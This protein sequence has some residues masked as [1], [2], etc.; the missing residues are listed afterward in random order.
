MAAGNAREEAM[1]QGLCELI[2]RDAWTLA[3]I[4]AHLLPW[5]RH[6]VADPQTLAAAQDDHQFFA[7]VDLE[8][9]PAIPPFER[10]GLHPILHDITS[11]I[12]IPTVFAAVADEAIP[13]FPMVH[14]GLGSHPDARVAAG[15]ALIE[16]AQSRCVDIQGV[17]EDLEPMD[18]PPSP[19]NL[20]TRRLRS[21]NRRQWQLGQSKIRRKLSELPSAEFDDVQQDLDYLLARLQSSGI[22]QVVAVD[23]TPPDAPFAVVRMIVPA[24][25][26]WSLAHGPLGQR[27]MEFWRRHG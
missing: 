18:A 11:D 22:H 26:T 20:H 9:H 2:E 24:L 13:G 21:V 16:A 5:V 27:A 4:G 19:L 14:C 1:C 8:D 25:E 10:A 15:R 3:E 6:R 17:R 12:G 23:F 7:C